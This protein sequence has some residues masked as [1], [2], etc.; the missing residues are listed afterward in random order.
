M[1]RR[2]DTKPTYTEIVIHD[3]TVYLSGQV[4]WKTANMQFRQQCLEVFQSI[5]EKL[6]QAGTEKRKILNLQ[7]F[8]K[9]PANYS[10][11]NEEFLKWI[12]NGFAPARNTICGVVFPYADWGLEIVV[13]AAL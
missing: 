2:I 3:K 8:L 1:I 9:D 12:P 11:F 4:P 13:T 5:D 6:E 7:I 10:I